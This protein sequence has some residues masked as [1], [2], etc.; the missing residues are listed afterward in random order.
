[1][2]NKFKKNCNV[3]SCCLQKASVGDDAHHG[4]AGS[5]EGAGKGTGFLGYMVAARKRQEQAA[6]P[7]D[8]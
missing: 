2:K 3:E 8:I 6:P 7:H 5:E 1:M 4:I